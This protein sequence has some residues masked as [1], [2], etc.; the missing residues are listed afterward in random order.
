[1]M[2]KNETYYADLITRYFSGE[3][4]AQDV[5]ELSEWVNANPGNSELFNE[6]RLTWEKVT[7]SLLDET[8]LDK[9]W[10][11]IQSGVPAQPVKQK[12][13]PE[14]KVVHSLLRQLSAK[15]SYR[16]MMRAAAVI[17]LLAFPA[18]L[19]YSYLTR[20]EWKETSSLNETMQII[21][22]DG[23]AVT[24][25]RNSVLGYPSSFKGNERSVTVSG[26]AWFTVAHDPGKPFKCKYQK[27]W[28]GN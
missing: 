1:M 7:T 3:T 25:N 11:V 15:Y 14:L 9:E 2:S 23:S 4:S 5:R 22:P 16:L 27:I 26:E 21:L 12:D 18:F 10:K 19:L 17:I 6:Y 28:W 13:R 20:P 24:L 8:D